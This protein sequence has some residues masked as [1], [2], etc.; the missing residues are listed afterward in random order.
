M[1]KTAYK[2]PSLGEFKRV[3]NEVNGH[4]TNAA[5]M[6]GCSRST[7]WQWTVDDPEFAEAVKESRKRIF[8]RCLTT[9]QALAFGV[10][11]MENGKVV[12]WIERPD[13]KILQ[14]L[15]QTIGRDEGFAGSFDITSNGKEINGG[16]QIEIIDKREDVDNAEDTDNEDL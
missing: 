1:P 6:L 12:G 10:P 8:D 15:M 16:I 9:A 3:L 14:Y 4:L 2:K 5:M 7:L 13:T 11:Q